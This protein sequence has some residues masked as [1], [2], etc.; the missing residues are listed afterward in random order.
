MPLNGEC[1]L[2]TPSVEASSA[3]VL[4][5]DAVVSASAVTAASELDSVVGLGCICSSLLVSTRHF[6]TIV[7]ARLR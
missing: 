3:S 7:V 6:D 2:L 5:S 1:H 4:V